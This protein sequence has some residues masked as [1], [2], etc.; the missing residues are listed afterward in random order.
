MD[1]FCPEPAEWKSLSNSSVPAAFAGAGELRIE[2]NLEL[3][4]IKK[5]KRKKG[6][7]KSLDA[8]KLL[9]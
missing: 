1:G 5:E 4:F 6:I 8:L 7:T 2:V 9:L 3:I